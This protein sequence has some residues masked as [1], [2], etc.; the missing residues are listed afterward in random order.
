MQMDMGQD[1]DLLKEA[2]RE[3]QQLVLKLQ[4][5]QDDVSS[6]AVVTAREA[7]DEAVATLSQQLQQELEGSLARCDAGAAGC[8]RVVQEA[9]SKVGMMEGQLR[10]IATDLRSQLAQEGGTLIEALGSSM[11]FDRS[12]S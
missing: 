8:E 6:N 9:L 5:E 11:R 1:L 7:A 10:S 2:L 4:G 3:V 12:Q